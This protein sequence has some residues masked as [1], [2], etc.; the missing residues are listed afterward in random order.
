[1][2]VSPFIKMTIEEELGHEKEQEAEN[3]QEEEQIPL[4]T[5][6]IEVAVEHDSGKYCSTAY[7]LQIVMRLKL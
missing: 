2:Y 5:G 7:C 6:N 4:T 1:M 3:S